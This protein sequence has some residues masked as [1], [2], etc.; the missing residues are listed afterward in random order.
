[1][2]EN[3]TPEESFSCLN[4]LAAHWSEAT[5]GESTA[6]TM[7]RYLTQPYVK[8]TQQSLEHRR[9]GEG[10]STQDRVGVGLLN[11]L[12]W[13]DTHLVRLTPSWCGQSWGSRQR[14]GEG[15]GWSGRWGGWGRTGLEWGGGRWEEWTEG[16]MESK[17]KQGV[18]QPMRRERWGQRWS[19]RAFHLGRRSAHIHSTWRMFTCP[20]SGK[21][22]TPYKLRPPEE[23]RAAPLVYMMKRGASV[24]PSLSPL[25]E[26]TRGLPLR[27]GRRI[28]D[29]ITN[30]QFLA[31]STY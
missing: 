23:T 26:K 29:W 9:W 19:S 30:P 8:E 28:T 25:A 10:E 20:R 21:A 27:N 13:T 24:L 7:P 14:K 31:A 5:A 12:W 15:P 2:W 17:T 6:L 3:V 11:V 1:M 18:S 4:Q 22:L 16:D